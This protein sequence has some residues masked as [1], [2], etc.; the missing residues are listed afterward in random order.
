MELN[1]NSDI[2][3][4]VDHG[5]PSRDS[6][7]L[8]SAWLGLIAHLVSEALRRRW[9]FGLTL[10][11]AP[12]NSGSGARG[13]GARRPQSRNTASSVCESQ[14]NVGE[15]EANLPPGR[16]YQ[17]GDHT[18]HWWASAYDRIC[19]I[20]QWLCR[21]FNGAFHRR[22]AGMASNNSFKPNLLRSTN[23]MAERA[24]HV[25]GYATQVGL[26][27]ALCGTAQTVGR[28]VPP[29]TVSRRDGSAPAR[30]SSGSSC[31][32]GTAPLR[33]VATWS[34]S[35]NRSRRLRLRYASSVLGKATVT[36]A[37]S[38]SGSAAF[39]VRGGGNSRSNPG[40]TA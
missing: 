33:Q 11:G 26:T 24:C 14:S 1:R 31:I 7:A 3:Y 9:A 2:A 38:V 8:P 12:N 4:F 10:W 23:N 6:S 18:W 32:T 15:H 39:R 19:A 16:H 27:Q 29:G 40:S 5:L 22:L 20:T 28:L 36:A 35:R 25:V 21:R 30:G 37:C 13:L 34:A 17:S